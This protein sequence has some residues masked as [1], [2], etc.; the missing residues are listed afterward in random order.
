MLNPETSTTPPLKLAYPRN[1]CTGSGK[2][3]RK[4]LDHNMQCSFC[5]AWRPVNPHRYV[6]P[7]HTVSFFPGEHVSFDGD[8]GEWLVVA[9]IEGEK[10]RISHAIKGNVIAY[11]DELQPRVPPVEP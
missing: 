2:Y 11:A 7:D 6:M 5:W 10:Y 3:P 1:F 9:V 4:Q 8:I